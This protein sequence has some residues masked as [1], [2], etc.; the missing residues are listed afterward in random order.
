MLTK[1]RARLG[2][3]RAAAAEPPFTSG[4]GRTN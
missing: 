4:A 2:L 3:L 1:H